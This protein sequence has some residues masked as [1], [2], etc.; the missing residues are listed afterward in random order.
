MKSSLKALFFIYVSMQVCSASFISL[1]TSVST[2]QVI[3][4]DSFQVYLEVINNGDETAYD[5]WA[6]LQCP[7]GFEVDDLFFGDLESKVPYSA[8]FNVS[9]GREVNPGSYTLPLMIEYR[10]AN[11]YLFSS[12]S[13]FPVNLGEKTISLVGVSGEGVSL[14]EGRNQLGEVEFT[15][16]NS[17]Q[18]DM[19]VEVRLFLPKELSG[20]QLER[21]TL[22]T[23]G[24]SRTVSFD[25]GSGTALAKSTYFAFARVSY[26]EDGLYHSNVSS[27]SVEITPA[28][29]VG[30]QLQ[31]PPWAS[32]MGLFFLI[33]L[34]I[35]LQFRK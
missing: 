13:V 20:Q 5:V 4:S 18:K 10:D 14:Q 12:L 34:F 23:P 29:G 28:G 1:T 16:R 19:D 25:V 7:E 17:A 35:I 31:L 9:G 27:I 26:T 6:S 15:L 11:G 33:G 30:K 3:L 22:L 8:Q 2:E 24:G 21:K 32:I